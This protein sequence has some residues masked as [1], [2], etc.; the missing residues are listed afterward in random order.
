MNNQLKDVL[1]TFQDKIQQIVTK[2]PKL[3]G[4]VSEETSERFD[5][6]IST[7][8]NQAT[9]IDVLHAERDQIEE[10]LQNEIKQLQRLGTEHC[11]LNFIS[12]SV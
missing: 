6:L 12:T 7:I 9:Q 8:E 11:L 1:Q 4:N 3:F 5:H 2:R 10:Q